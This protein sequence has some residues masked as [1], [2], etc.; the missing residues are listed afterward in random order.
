MSPKPLPLPLPL[1]RSFAVSLAWS[2]S[3]F[4]TRWRL[5]A[6]LCPSQA[7]VW[8]AAQQYATSPQPEHVLYVTPFLAFWPH[9]PHRVKSGNCC[10]CVDDIALPCFALPLS[11]LFVREEGNSQLFLFFFFF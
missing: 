9:S 4:A 10:C 8:H 2:H 5:Q 11:D 3:F 1:P 6:A 7:L